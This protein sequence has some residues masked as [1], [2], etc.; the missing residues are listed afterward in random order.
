[1]NTGTDT[2][3]SSVSVY[4]LGGQKVADNYADMYDGNWDSNVP[5]YPNGNNAPNSGSDAR[6]AHGCSPSG[7][8]H[9]RHLGATPQVNEGSPYLDARELSTTP[10]PRSILRR[11]YGLSDIFQVA[12]PT[13][14][15][16]TGTPTISGT[17]QVGETL[18]AAKGTIADDDGVTKADNG[19]SGFAYTYQWV[20]VDSGT[21]ADISGA[22]GVAYT[23]VDDD[24]GKTVKVEVSFTDDDGNDEG[25][26][27]SAETPTVVAAPVNAPPTASDN[28]V[29]M[30]ED[31]AHS[32][33][34]ANFNFADTD[35]DTLSL[36]EV[37]TL[38]SDGALTFD[39]NA[40]TAN[41]DVPVADIGDL[42]FTPAA[43]ATGRAM[44]AS[45]SR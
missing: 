4:W 5:K 3:D 44:R 41:L 19:D 23:L 12:T 15:A 31:T 36:V 20:R 14:N 38:P 7:G 18:T 26:L 43:N 34:A 9:S 6:T 35:G 17:T 37:V 24:L 30:D 11:Y 16:A 27:T 40:A 13:N 22:T 42:V 1:M 39:G 29:T 2:S 32:F 33:A 21:D 10:V 45:P 28:S 8:L 25:P